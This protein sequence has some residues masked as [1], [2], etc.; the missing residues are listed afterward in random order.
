MISDIK[1]I[2]FSTAPNF[3]P[4]HSVTPH[5]IVSGYLDLF[6]HRAEIL[7]CVLEAAFFTAQ[8][9]TPTR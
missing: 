7:T 4:H 8:N 3:S 2:D 6:S 9:Q 1:T 5:L